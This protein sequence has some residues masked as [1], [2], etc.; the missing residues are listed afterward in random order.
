MEREPNEKIHQHL[1]LFQS[2]S[3]DGR[4]PGLIEIEKLFAG[5]GMGAH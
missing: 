3:G 2:E 1:A 4:G 5:L